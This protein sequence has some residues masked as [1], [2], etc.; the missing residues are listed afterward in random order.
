MRSWRRRERSPQPRSQAGSAGRDPRRQRR[1]P[2]VPH[3]VR[4]AAVDRHRQRPDL[5]PDEGAGDQLEPAGP[6]RRPRPRRSR[7]RTG[8]A[9]TERRQGRHRRHRAARP[10]RITGYEVVKVGHESFDPF[11][12][13]TRQASARPER[14]SWAAG[15][16]RTTYG[17]TRTFRSIRYLGESRPLAHPWNRKPDRRR[18]LRHLRDLRDCL[19]R[20]L[21]H[22]PGGA[23][24]TPRLRSW[25]ATAGRLP[26]PAVPV[27]A[28]A[29][30]R[31]SLPSSERC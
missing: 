25:S 6:A 16:R 14:L 29:A 13:F 18:D 2:R 26:A 24:G 4:R 8:R 12:T 1:D 27:R 15:T 9:R 31:T 22:R 20:P 23:Y 19:A 28:A 21:Q 11:E 17:S 5:P 3:E 30:L 10:A 7:R